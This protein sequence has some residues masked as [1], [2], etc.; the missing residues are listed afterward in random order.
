MIK[1]V[2]NS[3][4]SKNNPEGAR[5]SVAETL[6]GL[7]EKPRLLFCFFAQKREDWENN[8]AEKVAG[9]KKM[10]PKN[11]TPH[12]E[13]AFPDKFEEQTKNSEAI[14][15]FGGDDHL[16]QYWLKQFDLPKIWQGKVVSVSSASSN[17][18]ATHFWT[19]DWRQ[20]LDG[21]GILPIKFIPHYKSNYG[22]DDP[23]GPVDWEKA[24]KELEKYGN[25]NLPIYALEEGEF[26]TIEK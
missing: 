13:L 11:I 12:F 25:K 16:V 26:I 1:Y 20:C 23:R 7:G 18:M 22:V 6:K 15:I 19:C 8:F 3:G 14:I 10:M 4:G 5:R 21:L 9:F 24:Y 2:I 17:A